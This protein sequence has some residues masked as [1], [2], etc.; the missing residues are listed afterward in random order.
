MH[1]LFKGPQHIFVVIDFRSHISFVAVAVVGCCCKVFKE[2]S[3]ISLFKTR[4]RVYRQITKFMRPDFKVF[5]TNEK[6]PVQPRS[7]QISFKK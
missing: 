5:T 2:M 6:N 3:K 1:D 4:V 7:I